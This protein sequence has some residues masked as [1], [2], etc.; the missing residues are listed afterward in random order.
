MGAETRSVKVESSRLPCGVRG[1]GGRCGNLSHG[2]KHVG[3]SRDYIET[4]LLL[5]LCETHMKAQL[6]TESANTK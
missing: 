4:W 3:V 6:R 2:I 1:L 5:V